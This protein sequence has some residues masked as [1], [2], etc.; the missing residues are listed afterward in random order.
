M[1]YFFYSKRMQLTFYLLFW[2]LLWLQSA[3]NSSHRY[4]V[5]KEYSK[6]YSRMRKGDM[7]HK[8]LPDSQLNDV[9]IRGLLEKY[10]EFTHVLQ[11]TTSED[12]LTAFRL[13]RALA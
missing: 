12:I 8:A 13:G 5:S 6:E 10:I 2:M 9:P 11:V 4:E 7:L 3:G 1:I